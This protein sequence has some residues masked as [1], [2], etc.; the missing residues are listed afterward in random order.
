MSNPEITVGCA[1]LSLRA[2]VGIHACAFAVD[3]GP[4]D[5]AYGMTQSLYFL[6]R[7]VVCSS[8]RMNSS[9]KEGFIGI[10]VT[11]P[12]DNTLVEKRRFYRGATPA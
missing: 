7:E 5:L 1:Q 12:G 2:N 4:K 3:G 9:S 11:D 10:H 6:T 8:Q